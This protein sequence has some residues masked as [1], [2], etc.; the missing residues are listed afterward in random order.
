MANQKGSVENLVGFVKKNF[1]FARTFR[2][3][4]DLA[5][6]LAHWLREVNHA[7]PCDATREIPEARRQAEIPWLARRPLRWTANEVPLRESR[8]V[9]PMATV[10]YAGTPYSAPPRRIGATATLLVRAHRIDMFIDQE[11]WSHVRKDGVASVQRLPEH[12]RDMLLVVHGDR[13]EN[14]F[15]RECLLELGPA[16]H[17]FM[18]QLVHRTRWSPE[19]DTLFELLQTHSP[20]AMCRA[21]AACHAKGHYSAAAVAGALRRAA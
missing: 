1:L 12:R 14:F 3:E 17:D 8:L 7:R 6:Q 4:A 16:A 20:E 19:V 11:R 13:K 21:M 10:S 2:D 9:T 5:E 18:E 15:K